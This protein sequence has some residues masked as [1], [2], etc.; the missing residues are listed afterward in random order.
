MAAAVKALKLMS[1]LFARISR[2]TEALGELTAT[3]FKFWY[4]VPAA[5]LS[6]TWEMKVPVE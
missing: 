1:V 4:F 3:Q 5:P 6:L 2:E